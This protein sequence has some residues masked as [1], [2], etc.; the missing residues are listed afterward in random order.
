MDG[1]GRRSGAIYRF[2]RFALDLDRGALLAADGTEVPLRPKSFAVLRLLAENAGRLLDRHAIA[3][4]VWSGLFVSD[5][6]IAQCV[7]D[8]RRARRRG[9]ALG[10]D[11]A[12]TRLHPRRGG[13][14]GRPRRAGR[15]P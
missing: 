9:A 7:K 12:E 10:A 3:A 14:A 11:G 6:C 13:V 1:A 8:V 5:E 2:D 15:R 4:A